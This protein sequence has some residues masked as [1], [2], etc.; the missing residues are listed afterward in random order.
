M[1]SSAAAYELRMNPENAAQVSPLLPSLSR[2]NEGS[3]LQ[4]GGNDNLKLQG[5]HG[6]AAH[7]PLLRRGGAFRPLLVNRIFASVV[8]LA[9]VF[10]ILRC[11]VQLGGGRVF[12]GAAR[13]LAGIGDEG[14]PEVCGGG[15]GEGVDS[16]AGGAEG[17]TNEELRGR[18]S[19]VMQM[20]LQLT[21]SCEMATISISLDNQVEVLRSLLV[22]AVQ[23]LSA[24]AEVLEGDL[25]E[26]RRQVAMRVLN[27]E[28]RFTRRP[29]AKSMGRSKRYYISS[30]KNLLVQVRD[31]QPVGSMLPPKE[32]MRKLRTLLTLQEVALGRAI[33][34]I[35]ELIP[36]A[37]QREKIPDAFASQQ[38]ARFASITYTRQFQ[39][40]TD[41]ALSGWLSERQLRTPNYG[42]IINPERV[43][44]LRER[45]ERPDLQEL[46]EQLE[47]AATQGK[48]K[49]GEQRGPAHVP[50]PQS[51]RS[52]A[53][54]DQVAEATGYAGE[55]TP[56]VEHPGMSQQ[57]SGSPRIDESGAL[58]ASAAEGGIGE[59]LTG[60]ASGAMR[61][62]ACFADECWRAL[63]VV[64]PLTRVNGTA[65]FLGLAVQEL[66]ALA[67]VLD[68][69]LQERRKELSRTVIERAKALIRS[70]P[71]AMREGSR[72]RCLSNLLDLVID[73]GDMAP[74]AVWMPPSE[75]RERL[76]T[77]VA[78]QEA[79]LE[80]AISAMRK[81]ES[82]SRQKQVST[83]AVKLELKRFA[84]LTHT[85][86]RQIFREPVLSQWL[87]EH[88]TQKR[89]GVLLTEKTIELLRRDGRVRTLQE[90]IAE[91]EFAFTHVTP[92]PRERG[93][94]AAGAE[95][96]PDEYKDEAE[97]ALATAEDVTDQEPSPL[98][99]S[100]LT[101]SFSRAP[102]A[103]RPLRTYTGFAYGEM[104]PSTSAEWDPGAPAAGP[105]PSESSS[106]HRDPRDLHSRPPALQSSAVTAS[107]SR[108]PGATRPMRAYRGFAYGELDS[109]TSAESDPGASAAGPAPS[110]SSSLH[111]DLRAPDSRPPKSEE[112]PT[113]R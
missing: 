13:S 57:P 95:A 112:G 44:A 52:E 30:L 10:A 111:Q 97:D 64:D 105:A 88:R 43:R 36:T 69:D 47:V 17:G 24:L 108:A 31:R 19:E 98:Q 55:P 62:L 72:R 56:T 25:E 90:L 89:Q 32:R 29:S 28:Q 81:L 80:R 71:R 107:F 22:T 3:V 46:I 23:E 73:V 50:G 2:S 54:A 16:H 92:A 82:I 1:G 76:R 4:A 18:A 45:G 27:M 5:S 66:A 39:L 100:A 12:G 49:R 96:Q 93:G 84:N 14:L 59:D 21:K 102:G 58:H 70:V 38:V 48:L 103:A 15:T 60:R 26:K 35:E 9:A 110:E 67:A 104:D 78:V 11:A 51:D 113:E 74:Q 65:L 94:A 63:Y 20:M 86:R 85:R 37:H 99:S 77:L 61:M 101:A 83:A 79:A 75:R 41:P 42:L 68:G 106:L 91:L 40:F 6:R 53:P 7:L 87:G 8:V 109:S 33:S 34:A